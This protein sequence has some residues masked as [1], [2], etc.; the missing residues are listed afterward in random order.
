[1]FSLEI[2]THLPRRILIILA[3]DGLTIN[4]CQCLSIDL[5]SVNV[6]I[7][8]YVCLLL[9]VSNICG[10]RN[11]RKYI[12][13][14]CPWQQMIK[15]RVK[16]SKDYRGTIRTAVDDIKWSF[17]NG[18]VGEIELSVFVVYMNIEGLV[19]REVSE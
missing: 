12:C 13:S 5:F 9:C 15:L 2:F 4:V 8:L 6:S 18:F 3:I 10:S 1:M 7:F 14:N 17:Q 19:V 16:H 11:C